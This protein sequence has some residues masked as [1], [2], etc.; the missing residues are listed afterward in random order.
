MRLTTIAL[1]SLAFGMVGLDARAADLPPAPVLDDSDEA[2]DAGWYLRGDIGAIDHLVARHGRDFGAGNVPPLVGTRFSRDVVFSGGVGYRFTPWL[3]A[4]VTIDHRFEAAFRG[5][6]F[7]S[8]SN[9]AG[10]RADVEA[11][12]F[13]ANGYVDLDLWGG[14]TPYLGAGIGVS[15][16]RF[17]SGERLVTMAG[18]SVVAP[19]PSRTHNVFAWALMAGVA[20]DITGNLTLDLGYRYTRLGNA[21]T[22]FDGADIT[23]RARD[24]AAHEFRVG[25]RYQ[26][27]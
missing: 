25:A 17:D 13:L 7:A 15:R 4:D 27:D 18:A 19:L 14:I 2:F 11:T 3:R 1:A 24:I 8:A 23:P 16:N 5:T 9:H 6:R 21:G 26:F 10:D 12:T 20:F 22:G